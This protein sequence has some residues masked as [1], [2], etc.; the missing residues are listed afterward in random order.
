MFKSNVC[1]VSDSVINTIASTLH[2][3]AG[4]NP[5]PGSLVA[6][7]QVRI[8]KP[9]LAVPI[10]A[11]LEYHRGS[12]IPVIPYNVATNLVLDGVAEYCK[13]SLL[14]YSMEDY[15][16]DPDVQADKAEHDRAKES[17]EELAA[18]AMIGDS[19]SCLA[20]CRNIVSGCQKPETL[21]DDAAGALEA[22]NVFL[23]EA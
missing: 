6:P 15:L 23:I 16:A 4:V 2:L 8:T 7:R 1:R 3:A 12:M 18:V 10:A 5:V 19:R 20:V 11:R 17:G 14:C 22:A 13:Q 9:E 21:K